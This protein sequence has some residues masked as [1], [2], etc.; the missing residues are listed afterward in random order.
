MTTLNN[1]VLFVLV[2]FVL[3]FG[4]VVPASAHAEEGVSAVVPA[5]AEEGVQG[6]CNVSLVS[7]RVNPESNQWWRLHT[8][9]D[10]S[11]NDRSSVSWH[12]G[13]H[14]RYTTE[15]GERDARTEEAYNRF[16]SHTIGR[17]ER[18]RVRV[19]TLFAASYG[20]RAVSVYDVD[21]FTDDIT[22][23]GIF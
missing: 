11:T 23:T 9:W 22:C 1:V 10:V 17:N 4:S 3:S 5:H 8:V 21:V 7:H 19:S 20:A 15:R 13:F 14:Y 12:Y 6:R 18:E 16:E 2:L